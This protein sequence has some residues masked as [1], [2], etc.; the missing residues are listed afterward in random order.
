[1]P[2]LVQVL[3]SLVAKRPCLATPAMTRVVQGSADIIDRLPQSDARPASV[4]VTFVQ[5]AA[6]GVPAGAVAHCMTTGLAAGIVVPHVPL[7][8]GRTWAGVPP[9][10]II[11]EPAM[12]EPAMPEPPVPEPP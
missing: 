2:S 11:A 3:P 9:V 8:G 7:A 4:P 12:P 5:V 1:M 6:G 10:P